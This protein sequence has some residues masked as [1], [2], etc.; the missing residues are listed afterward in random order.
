MKLPVVFDAYEIKDAIKVCTCVCAHVCMRMCGHTAQRK[1]GQTVLHPLTSCSCQRDL[2]PSR[3]EVQVL[4]MGDFPMRVSF[5][6]KKQLCLEQGSK[7]KLVT[8]RWG[9]DHP[10]SLG[11]L[12]TND[13][14]TLEK[15]KQNKGRRLVMS[16]KTSLLEWKGV[17]LADVKGRISPVSLLL[18]KSPLCFSV[19]F[20]VSP[21]WQKFP[22]NTSP[23]TYHRSG[24]GGDHLSL[25]L[26]SK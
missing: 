9:W 14:S 16:I 15:F 19:C 4:E 20:C 13:R 8:Q 10:H 21:A 12:L 24:H 22:V 6:N 1:P 17:G 26:N 18:P 5:K 2:G 23:F 7:R 3:V 11:L 25:S